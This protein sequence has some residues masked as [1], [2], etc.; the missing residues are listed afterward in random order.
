MGAVDRTVVQDAVAAVIVVQAV[1]DLD[2]VQK[3]A[4]EGLTV[5]EDPSDIQEVDPVVAVVEAAVANLF[6]VDQQHRAGQVP[7]GR[8]RGAQVAQTLQVAP[9]EKALPFLLEELLGVHRCEA[10]WLPFAA[11]WTDSLVAVERFRGDRRTMG[12]TVRAA[13]V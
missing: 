6:Q 1:A 9:I 4:W 8:R 12:L 2:S 5:A 10:E 7:G 13:R 11:A 3:H